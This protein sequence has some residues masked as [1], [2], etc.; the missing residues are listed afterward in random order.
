MMGAVQTTVVL[1]L[2][3]LLLYAIK[4]FLYPKATPAPLP[5][6]PKGKFVVG[7]IS[8]LPPPGAQEWSHWGRHKDIY[9]PISSISVMGTVMIVIND[10]KIAFDLLGKRSSAYSERPSLTF[11]NEMCGWESTLASLPYNERFRQYRRNIHAII[12]TKP[13]VSKFYDL[14]EEEARRFA[15]RVLKAPNNLLQHARA[16]AGAVILK[17]TYGY[18][19]EPHEDDYLVNTADDALAQFSLA[20]SPGAWIVDVMPFLKHI[21]GW[22]PGTEFKRTAARWKDTIMRTAGQ[23]YNFVMKQLREGS[24][25]PSYLQELLEQTG[26][27][28]LTAEDEFVAKWSA[29]SLYTGGADTTVSSIAVFFLSMVLNPL[30]QQKAQQEIDSVVGSERLPTFSDRDRLPYVDAILKEVLRWHPVAPMG[31]PHVS[32]EN[33]TYEGYFIPAGALL[34]PNIYGFLHD[35]ETYKCPEQF[36]PDRFLGPNAEPDSRTLSFGFGRRICPGRELAD[37]SLWITIAISLASFKITKPT[38]NGHEVEP[39][40]YF[41]PGI[42]SHPEPFK[43]TICPR[44]AKAAELIRVVEDEHPWEV[45]ESRIVKTMPY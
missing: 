29:A 27:D 39:H 43:A 6:G 11:G 8:D 5:P 3:S 24:A 35:P 41:R 45:S 2:G 33:D 22:V 40:V 30:V 13:A 16:E 15:L 26:L 10:A 42:I 4:Q 44:S 1:V 34:I 12:G 36:S 20:T 23:P 31:I 28:H 7:N 9:G 18:T 32:R 17:I 37:S 38:E 14:Q 25:K 19:T 21:P